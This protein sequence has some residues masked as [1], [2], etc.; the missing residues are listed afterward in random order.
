MHTLRDGRRVRTLRALGQEVWGKYGRHVIMT[1]Q[2]VDMVSGSLNYAAA[3][4]LNLCQA[5]VLG[6]ECS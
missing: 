1:L 2:M 4:E 6:K 3:A 5:A